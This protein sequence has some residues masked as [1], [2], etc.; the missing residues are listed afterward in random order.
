MLRR[1][2]S[3]LKRPNLTVPWICQHCTPPLLHDLEV[4]GEFLGALNAEN[5]IK[6][7]YWVASWSV[8]RY[9]PVLCQV[10]E[11][12]S[13][14]LFNNDK[15]KKNGKQHQP[16][17]YKSSRRQKLGGPSSG[18]KSLSETYERETASKTLNES[19]PRWL[20]VEPTPAT[21]RSS[22]IPSL[23]VESSLRLRA[24]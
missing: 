2:F 5:K 20:L 12:N 22:L 11:R 18:G 24:R 15:V 10:E 17:S 1:I 8:S 9:H 4:H 21:G 13:C 16:V 7:Q 6:T 23:L 3:F 14:I 19:N